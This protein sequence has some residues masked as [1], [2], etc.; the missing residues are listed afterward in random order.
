MTDLCSC[1]AIPVNHTNLPMS[2]AAGPA[3]CNISLG[4]LSAAQTSFGGLRAYGSPLIR[5]II[6]VQSL[7]RE[8]SI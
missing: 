1:M 7:Y 3:G 8:E 2:Y 4:S 6:V 5:K